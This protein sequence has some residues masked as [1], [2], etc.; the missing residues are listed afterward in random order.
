M[1]EIVTLTLNPAVDVWT[2]VDRI[3]DTHKLRCEPTRCYP[4]GGGIN[5]A[6]VI[7][8]L[9]GQQAR[10]RALYLAGGAAGIRLEQMLSNERIPNRRLRIAGETR[11]NFS[12]MERATGREFRFVLPGP[13][14]SEEE[15]QAAQM[16]LDSIKAAPGESGMP[17]YWVMSG[18]LPP[19]L[20]PQ[21]Y[22]ELARSARLR[23]MRVVLDTSGTALSLALDAG[24][25]LVKP[26]LSELA[27]LMGTPLSE[28]SDWTKAARQIVHDGRAQIVALTLGARGALLVSSEETIRLQALSVPVAGAT[29]AGDSFLAGLLVALRRGDPLRDAAC[30]AQA[31]ASATLLSSGT[32]LCDPSEVARLCADTRRVV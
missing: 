30:L 19:G 5:V 23:G 20:P 8:R 24:V 13:Y 9:D 15:W 18:S 2:A 3:V 7:R 4:G 27:S 32:A 26:S 17:D 29:G 28:E 22:A 12:V 11:E 1:A 31:A 6:R 21:A 16:V 10:C 25:Y 14:V